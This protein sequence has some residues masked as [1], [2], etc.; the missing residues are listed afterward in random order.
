MVV[1]TGLAAPSDL[2]AETVSSSFI[3]LSWNDNSDNED[4]FKIEYGFDGDSWNSIGEIDAG[5]ESIDIINCQQSTT[6]YFRIRAFNDDGYSDYSNIASA[7]TL[8][9]IFTDSFDSDSLYAVP[10]DESWGWVY[11]GTSRLYVTD[12]KSYPS[13]GRCVKF[14]DSD[15]G[16]EN[17]VVLRLVHTP[18]TAG[19]LSMWL[20]ISQ[21]GGFGING[22]EDEDPE[23]YREDCSFY[24]Q[25]CNNGELKLANGQDSN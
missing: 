24:L 23:D 17:Y 7:T 22:W 21:E 9:P 25:F 8:T 19:T 5:L 16:S 4:G 3:Y 18:V 2:R 1:T 13:G 12:E 20:Y 10:D 14:I 6:Y 15:S 11:S